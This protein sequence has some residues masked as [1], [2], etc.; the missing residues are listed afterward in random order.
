[1]LAVPAA[2]AGHQASG[3]RPIELYKDSGQI[4]DLLDM[5]F[6]PLPGGRGQRMLISST[7]SNAGSL[8][9]HRLGDYF[10]G[11]APGLVW[12]EDGRIVGT[13]SLLAARMSGRYLIANVAV[14]PD[15]RR[16]GIATGLMSSSMDYIQSHGGRE[17]LLQVER[18]NEAAIQLYSVLNYKTLGDVNRWES[19]SVH[20]RTIASEINPGVNIRP[21]SRKDERAAFLLDGRCMPFDLRWPNPP[22]AKKYEMSL[23]RRMNDFFNGRRMNAWV[24]DVPLEGSQKRRL[25]G[26]AYVESEWARPHELAIRIAADWRGRLERALFSTLVIQIKRSRSGRLLTS[27]LAHDHFMNGLLRE[28]DFKVKRSLRVMRFNLDGNE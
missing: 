6:G 18:D 12:E 19:N 7:G 20:L 22:S 17:I 25:I 21:L 3:P 26:L 11:I 4:L 14:H 27:H 8:F 13:L 2:V 9:G 16:R 5:A 28:A 1:M 23:W 10:R 24:A 15:Y